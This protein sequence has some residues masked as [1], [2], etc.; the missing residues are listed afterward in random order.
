MVEMTERRKSLVVLGGG[1]RKILVESRYR[2]ISRSSRNCGKEEDQEEGRMN[3]LQYSVGNRDRRVDES[4]SNGEV[5]YSCLPKRFVRDCIQ[6]E[7]VLISVSSDDDSL[8]GVT[9]ER[10]GRTLT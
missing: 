7:R 8:T 3:R 4:R 5:D 6:R 9:T 1:E 10:G 2:L